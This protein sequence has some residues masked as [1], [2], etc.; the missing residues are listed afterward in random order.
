MTDILTEIARKHLRITTLQEQ[1][2]DR[3][4]FHNVGVA[5]LK[6]ALEAAYQ[7][8]CVDGYRN[9]YA[10]ALDNDGNSHGDK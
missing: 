4:D 9:G 7:A 6:A 8:G 5:S 2:A 1:G 3:L 10:N